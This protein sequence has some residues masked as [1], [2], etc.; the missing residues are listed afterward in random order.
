[1]GLSVVASAPPLAQACEHL[2][3]VVAR[4]DT[5]GGAQEMIIQQRPVGP[6][7]SNQFRP[8]VFTRAYQARSSQDIVPK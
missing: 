6:T 5:E 7:A 2:P 8:L 4:K 1:M 3:L